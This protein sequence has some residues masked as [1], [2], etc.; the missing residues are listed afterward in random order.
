MHD[1]AVTTLGRLFLNACRIHRKPNRMMVKKDGAW[2]PI[3]TDEF[4]T[5]VRRLSL[6]FQALGLKPGDRVALL[7][8]NRPE[9]VMADFAALTAGGV[10]VPIYAS[11]LPDQVRYIVDDSAAKI[12]VCSDRDLLRKVE[13]VRSSLPSVEHVVLLEGEAPEGTLA[14]ADVL[15]RGKRL[16]ETSPGAFERSAEA[17]LPGDLASIIYTSGTTGLPKGVMLSHANF[18]SNIDSLRAVIDFRADDTILSFLPLSHVLERTATFLFVH[19]GSAIAYAESIEAVAANMVEVRPTI[20]VSVPRLFEKIYARV[21][22][23]ILAGSRL[24]RAIF[25]WA[26]ATGKKY[27]ARVIAHEPVPKHLALKRGLAEKLV[28]SKITSKTGGRMRFF[29]CGGAPLS[30][31]IAE[32]FYAMGL[33][34]LPGYGLTETSPVLAANTLNDYRFDTV[35]KTVPGVE[36]RI[37]ADGEILAR[38]PNV[39]MGYYKNET[40]TREVM[41]GGWLY[42]G[43]IGRFDADGFLTITDRKKDIIVTSG[44]KNIAPQPIESLIQSSP[45][46]ANAVVVGST[47]RFISALIVPDFDKLE[48]RARAQGVPFKDRAELCRR[49]ELIDFLLDEV[50]RVTPDLAPYER[51]KKIAVLDRDFDIGAGEVTPTLKVKRNIVEQKYA[52]LIEAL[53]RD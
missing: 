28:Y 43:D 30:K 5:T 6:G 41:K 45:Y 3:A 24:K 50:S 53:Y 33:I 11:L 8:E 13:A 49:T 35:G 47:R 4:E 16:D 22:D 19:S 48:S 9:W 15:D 51:V 23:Q 14:F 10:T 40:D 18:V 7:S 44:G 32:F 29:V 2:R 1:Y 37:A 36:L 38:G 46:I 31:D 21:M 20:V 17:A 42:T 39:M 52:D 34:V 27:A 25:V 12:V 26:L